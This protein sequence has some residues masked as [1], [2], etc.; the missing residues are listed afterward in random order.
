MNTCSLFLALGICTLPCALVHGQGV[1]RIDGQSHTFKTLAGGDAAYDVNGASTLGL[2]GNV[3]N[4][5]FVEV[6]GRSVIYAEHLM[7]E[8][9]RVEKELNGQSTMVLKGKTISLGNINGQCTV[10]AII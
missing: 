9:I 3:N 4:L 10:I 1:T 8:T 6:N 7:A 2:N 5:R